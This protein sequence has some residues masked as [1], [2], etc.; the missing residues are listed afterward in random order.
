MK[1]DNL[2][3]PK[4]AR[5]SSKRLGR[6]QGSGT[7][8]TS[9]RGHKG[10][11]QR[12]GHRERPW[13]EGGQM[14]LSRRLP[15]RGFS[16]NQFREEFQIVNIESLEKI[17]VK[18]INASAMEKHG[19]VKSAFKPIKVLGRGTL[20]KAKN[21]TATAFSKSAIDK[22]EKSGGTVTIR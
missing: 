20:E 7:G 1:L 11:G 4:S 10:A 19:L 8:K 5:K 22:I 14:P 15:K 18:K 9:G 13:F 3:R 17:S 16:N 2:K 6:G 21:V 12:S